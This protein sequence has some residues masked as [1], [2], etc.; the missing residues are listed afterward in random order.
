M[1]SQG[2][3]ESS[4][5]DEFFKLDLKELTLSDG[6]IFKLMIKN[7]ISLNETESLKTCK[8]KNLSPDLFFNLQSDFS[9]I[10]YTKGF[11][12][13]ATL[14]V[15]KILLFSDMHVTENLKK[16]LIKTLY[17]SSQRIKYKIEPHLGQFQQFLGLLIY[18]SKDIPELVP[19]CNKLAELY[20]KSDRKVIKNFY[21]NHRES[22][23]KLAV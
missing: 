1:K 5:L 23:L 4:T 18:Y 21:Y 14:I 13:Q 8:I 7:K 12:E 3:I 10:N 9:N 19:V 11:E 2:T 22:K 16:I 15:D 20:S 17:L 6:Y